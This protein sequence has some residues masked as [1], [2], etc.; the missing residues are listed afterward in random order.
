MRRFLTLVLMAVTVS[1]GAQLR[2]DELPPTLKL[3]AKAPDFDLPG[4]D[5]KNWSL[6]DFSDAKLLVVIF[7][8]NHC[9]TAQYYEER[10]KDLTAKY[11]EKGVSVVAIMPNDPKSVRLDELAWTDLSDTFPEMKRRAKDRGYNFPYLYDGDTEDTSRA[12]GP[13]VT[14]HAYVFDQARTLR[15]VGAIDDSER[16]QHVTTH[17][18]ADA[19]DALLAGREPEPAQTKVVGCSIKWKGK[20]HQTVVFLEKL[21]AEPVELVKADEGARRAL[22]KN[23]SGKFRLVNFWATW[24]APCVAEFDELVAM[25]R[26]YRMRDFEMVTVSLNRPDEEA[27]VLGFLKKKQSSGRNL[28]FASAK[29][30]P[31]INAFDPDWQGVVPYTLLINPEGKVVYKE[32]GS[33][34]THKLKQA[35]VAELNARKP[36]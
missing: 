32:T 34:D 20:D 22:R 18:L 3:G 26:S 15:Y 2:A 29:R 27:S 30:D 24:C 10:I 35:I 23:D 21:A 8:C 12:Y 28:I 4:I 19:L 33:I 36:W 7:T 13:V 6:K 14:P 9:P 11:K 31:L 5:G 1:L 25:N 17:Y 16:I